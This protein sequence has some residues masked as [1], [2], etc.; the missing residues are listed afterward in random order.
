MNRRDPV[1]VCHIAR[2]NFT[3]F[4]QFRPCVESGNFSSKDLICCVGRPAH[5]DTSGFQEILSDVNRSVHVTLQKITL[6]IF[7]SILLVNQVSDFQ[8]LKAGF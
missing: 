1:G 8:A 5:R 7:L 2:K 6:P 3:E 4:R